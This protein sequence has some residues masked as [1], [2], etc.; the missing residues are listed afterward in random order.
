MLPLLDRGHAQLAQESRT[1]RH[2]ERAQADAAA[3]PVPARPAGPQQLH[4]G[5]RL[6]QAPPPPARCHG[7]RRPPRRSSVRRRPRS[8]RARAAAAPAPGM[9][10]G[11]TA[12]CAAA[13]CR[14]LGPARRCRQIL[15]AR[16]R[17]FSLGPGTPLPTRAHYRA[18]PKN[19]R[20]AVTSCSVTATLRHARGLRC[21]DTRSSM[22][23]ACASTQQA[24][25][26][27]APSSAKSVA[28]SSSTLT[29]HGS[30]ASSSPL[31]LRVAPPAA[32][33][34]PPSAARPWRN[35]LLKLL[36]DNRPAY[37]G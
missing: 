8:P 1:R 34:A 5:R 30:S 15:A 26:A 3:R 36:Q 37:A 25:P 35:G 14:L 6:R 18:Q 13:A 32:L 19:E 20:G 17:R 11:P 27:A 21:P 24:R 10:A 12:R 2:I 16:H 23:S 7:A 33:P 29:A 4:A 28:S 31:A 22:R 9:G